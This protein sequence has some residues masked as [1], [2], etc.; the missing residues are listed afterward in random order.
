MTAPAPRPAP[1]SLEQATRDARAALNGRTLL[2]LLVEKVAA[3]LRSG[4][5]S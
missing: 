3:R 5:D 2:R 4:R 1:P